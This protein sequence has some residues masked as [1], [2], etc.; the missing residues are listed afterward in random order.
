MI[1]TVGKPKKNSSEKK[2]GYD[3]RY[4]NSINKKTEHLDVSK[5]TFA[6]NAWRTNRTMS[7]FIDT[8][9]HSNEMNIYHGLDAQMQY[10]YLYNSIRKNPKRFF[11]R[12]KQ[13]KDIEFA[14]VQEFYKYNNERTREALRILSPEQINEIIKR[15]EKGGIVK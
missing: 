9:M 4:E 13:E 5:Q 12:E 7:N 1:K 8:I 2:D 15:L 10:D 14:L 11:K 3:W 6:Y